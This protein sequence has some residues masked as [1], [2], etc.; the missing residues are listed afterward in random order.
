MQVEKKIVG[1][2]HVW[3]GDVETMSEFKFACPVCGQHITADS[4]SSG[5]QLDCPTCFRKIIV[6]QA[7]TGPDSKLIL[8]ASQ[9]GK[10]RPSAALGT[11]EAA[12]VSRAS[13]WIPTVG[14]LL[15]LVGGGT[16]FYLFRDRLIQPAPKPAPTAAVE[17][18]PPTKPTFPIP[19]NFAWSLDLTNAPFPDTVAAGSIHGMGFRCQR[20]I[21]QGGT[22]SLRQGQTNPPD[23]QLVVRFAARQGEDLAGRTIQIPPTRPPPLPGLTLQ[24]VDEAHG[25]TRQGFGSG[26]ALKIA[27]GQP[28]NGRMPGRLFVCAPDAEKSFVAG[29]F[30]AELRKAPPPK[31]AVPRPRKN[32]LPTNALPITTR[33]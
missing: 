17:P 4:S 27:F 19:T 13:T 33:N 9:V 15:V 26:Y 11:A 8:S 5:G 16:A 30:E 14:L 12:P 18:A 23:L 31:P 22:L 10:P 1:P 28:A 2:E 7:P 25:V 3:D 6:P 29:T 20:A 32:P 21:L 24:W